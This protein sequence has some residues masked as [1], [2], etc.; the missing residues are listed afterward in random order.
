MPLRPA[1]PRPRAAPLA[2]A[3][4]LLAAAAAATLPPASAAGPEWRIQAP[5]FIENESYL[6]NGSIVVAQGGVLTCRNAAVLF[7][8][9]VSGE[10]KLE[11]LAGGSL[12]LDNCTLR[13]SDAARA[14]GLH[15]NFLVSG[16]LDARLADISDMRGDAG[17]G[18]LEANVGDVL[19]EDSRIHH[20]RY[21]GIMLKAGVATIRNTTFD[22]NVVGVFVTPG[23]SPYL[24]NVTVTNS[25]SF[26]LKVND[27]S[28]VVRNLT[29]S[30]GTGF[31]VG[32]VGAILDIVGCR[33]SGVEVGVDAVLGTTGRVEGCEFLTVATAVR[34]SNS[35]LRVEG[36]TIFGSGIGVNA[37][38][39]AVVVHGN[40][41][42]QV[43]L[44]VRAAGSAAGPDVGEGTQ[45]TFTGSGVG[46]VIYVPNFF[47]EGNTYGQ[48]MT[49]ARVFHTLTLEVVTK[50]GAPVQ[51][52]SVQI[53][54]ADGSPA[55][56]GFTNDTGAVEATLEHF[57]DLSNGSRQ[58][59]TPHHV[60]IETPGLVTETT[61]NAT[62]DR[63][64]RIT[65]ADAAPATPLGVSREALILIAL[66]LGAVGAGTLYRMRAR[67]KASGVTLPV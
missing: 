29:V 52:A 44:G 16:H 61:L 42:D 22:S 66:V 63:T 9:N 15:W 5:E 48:G 67:R 64:E 2:W 14:L 51:R 39:S 40:T 4:L 45:N 36:C 28:P 57:R 7:N 19:I 49:G 55:F 8:L 41:F 21:Y 11:V 6:A 46:F 26:G 10:L 35:P 62:S 38:S 23:A 18:G 50:A 3:A 12:S 53:T 24:E 32:A 43:A 60:R 17:L 20:N 1:A 58:N 47:L 31:G 37:T 56:S 59:V 13:A 30:G 27:A 25:T 54:T 33:V 34:A 65:L